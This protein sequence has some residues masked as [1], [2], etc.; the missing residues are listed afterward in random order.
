MTAM[1]E[2][3]NKADLQEW[4]GRW[5]LVNERQREEAARMTPAEK[6]VVL[7]RL[8]AARDIFPMSRRTS[9]NEEARELWMRLRERMTE[10]G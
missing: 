8:M 6:F 5:T 9:S 2:P 10:R 4:L 3:M 1:S 7:S